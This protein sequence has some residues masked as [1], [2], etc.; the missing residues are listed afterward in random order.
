MKCP[1]CNYEWETKSK[2]MY[3]CCPNCRTKVENTSIKKKEKVK[4]NE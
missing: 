2:L 3:V 4:K 1:K